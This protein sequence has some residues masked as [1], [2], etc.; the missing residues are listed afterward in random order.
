MVE[1]DP[2]RAYLA[3][4]GYARHVIEGGL[5]GLVRCWEFLV[6]DIVTDDVLGDEEYHN[7]M[8]GRRI[9][10]EALSFAPEADRARWVAHV[11]HLDEIFRQH[12][13]PT[14][15]CILGEENARKY[16]YTRDQHW[17]YYYGPPGVSPDWRAV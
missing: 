4:R 3:R 6:E 16:G 1:N 11:R 12:A 15:G 5:E 13:V 7:D 14:R 17:W 10:E 9:L 2:V 8:D